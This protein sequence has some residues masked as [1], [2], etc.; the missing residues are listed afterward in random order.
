MLTASVSY[1]MLKL[2]DTLRLV[3]VDVL[4]LLPDS[5]ALRVFWWFASALVLAGAAYLLTKDMAPYAAGSGIPDVKVTLSGTGMRTVKPQP[6]VLLTKVIGLPLVIGAGV[7]ADI[8]DPMT[9]IGGLFTAQLLQ[10]PLFRDILDAPDLCKQMVIAG[11]SSGLASYFGTPISGIIFVLEI[12]P[13]YYSV[14]NYW[15]AALSSVLSA[16]LARFIYN[17]FVH[18]PKHKHKQAQAGAQT[19]D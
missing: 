19:R 1:A 15:F 6:R 17:M 14:R 3:R 9:R 5:E 8:Q 2:G 4:S 11:T 18:T 7:F 12:A 10:L 13:S 16:M